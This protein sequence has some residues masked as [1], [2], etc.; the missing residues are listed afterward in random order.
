MSRDELDTLSALASAEVSQ[1]F[2][3]AAL[4]ALNRLG[5][6][7]FSVDGWKLTGAGS[8]TAAMCAPGRHTA[9]QDLNAVAN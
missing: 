9:P 8:L 3:G 1:G 5:L 4:L 7:E 2:S 6:I